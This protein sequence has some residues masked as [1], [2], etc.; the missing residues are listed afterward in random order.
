MHRLQG[1]VHRLHR[2]GAVREHH[3]AVTSIAP[4]HAALVVRAEGRREEPIGMQAL[5]PLAVKPIGLLAAGDPLGLAGIEQEHRP[6]R[7]SHS[8]NKG[9][10]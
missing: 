10:Q 6:P 7:A 4:Q 8:A 5:Q 2:V 9:I 3:L 1:L